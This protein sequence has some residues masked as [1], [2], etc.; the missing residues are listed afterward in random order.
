MK[1]QPAIRIAEIFHSIQGEGVLTGV[2]SVFVRVSGCNLRC[3]WCDTPY[4]SWSPEGDELSLEQIID[5]VKQYGCRYVVLTGGEPMIMPAIGALCALLRRA[6]HHITIETAAT[7]FHP[8][9][10][11]LASMS[12]KLSNSTPIQREG[13]RFAVMHEKQRLRPGIIQ[14]FIDHAREFQLKFVVSSES[15][16]QEIRAILDQLHGWQPADIL[17]MP[18]GVDMVTLQSRA[19]W[20]AEICKRTGFRYCPRLHVQL[21]GNQ[22]G[23]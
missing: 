4:A 14:Q 17:L 6:D 9:E 2:A 20:I 7:V 19:Q 16:V 21:Y 23:T 5:A 15:D 13:G 1:N 3:T 18:E 12:P 11:D 22:R 10:V 8:V